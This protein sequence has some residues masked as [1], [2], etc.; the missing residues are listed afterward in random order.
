MTFDKT[1]IFRTRRDLII[2]IAL[3][4]AIFGVYG[5]LFGHDFVNYDDPLYITENPHLCKGLSSQGLLWALTTEYANFWH[6]LTWLSYLA[7]YQLFGLAPGGFLLTNLLLH[8]LSS[9][10]LFATLR[11]MTGATWRSAMVA[12]LFALHPINVESVAWVAERK[13]T[14]STFL[15][16]LAM[17]GYA[18]YARRPTRWG[19]ILVLAIFVLG[20]MAK[21]MLITLPF[22]FLLLDYWPL[23]RWKGLGSPIGIGDYGSSTISA[24]FPRLV[25]EKIPFF[26]ISAVFSVIA[27]IAQERGGALASLTKFPLSVRGA[28][29]VVSYARY[30][31]KTIWPADLAIFY[32]HHGMPLWQELSGAL[33]VLALIT[34]SAVFFVRKRPWFAVGWFWYLGTLV[35]V[36]GLV[37]IGIFSMA[38][39][40]AYIPLIGLFILLI[41]G[42]DEFRVYFSLKPRVVSI[43]SVL[44]LTALCVVTYRQVG[45]WQNGLLLFQHA[46]RVT[47]DNPLALNNLGQS[48]MQRNELDLALIQFKKT[49]ALVP[50]YEALT[51]IG[52]ILA[53]QGKTKE[54]KGYWKQAI[55]LSPE[56]S[57][58]IGNL[59]MM[60]VREGRLDTGLDYLSKAVALDSDLAEVH[61][62]LG[63]ALLRKGHLQKAIV[64]F[65]TA[66]ALSPKGVETQIE[67]KKALG[68]YESILSAADDLKKALEE[69]KTAADPGV[70]RQALEKAISRYQRAVSRLP[71]YARESFDRRAIPEV[72]WVLLQYS[73]KETMRQT[74]D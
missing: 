46:L 14:L 11:N 47:G 51:N 61:S 57:A 7:D 20:L 55:A 67:L 45:Y 2:G 53:K 15:W 18:R 74:I 8:T 22:A 68:F 69:K 49:L 1:D 37:Q 6:P 73:R 24:S 36:I 10:L 28:N 21:P 44:I 39:R 48:Y 25:M 29:A 65:Q 12:A 60:L 58:A 13:N 3:V 56:K 38:D 42:G 62:Y 54:A 70:A 43:L 64:C 19:V 27:Y 17:W 72:E 4:V 23:G 31:K 5:G 26:L 66:L 59:G 32:P 30:V 33:L 9:L 35:P 34:L 71:G 16:M 50:D 41:W 40:F 52:V 63:M